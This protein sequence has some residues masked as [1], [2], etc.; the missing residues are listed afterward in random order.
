VFKLDLAYL[1]LTPAA[2][3]LPRLVKHD[4]LTPVFSSTLGRLKGCLQP[5]RFDQIIDA[6][7]PIL[8]ESC[9]SNP[10]TRVDKNDPFILK[11]ISRSDGAITGRAGLFQSRYQSDRGIVAMG[12][13]C[14]EPNRRRGTAVDMLNARS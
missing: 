5:L 3:D 1:C 13:W 9:S 8:I 6:T 12:R 11:P 4:Q 7:Y 10:C 2:R 14:D